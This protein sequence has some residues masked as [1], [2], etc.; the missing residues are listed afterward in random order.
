MNIE[1]DLEEFLAYLL[2]GAIVLLV[3]YPFAPMGVV[4]YLDSIKLPGP[5]LVTGGVVSLSYLGLALAAG[6]LTTVWRRFIVQPL[7]KK[8][9]GDPQYSIV[10]GKDHSFFCESAREAVSRQ[11]KMMG[12]SMDDVNNRHVIPDIIRAHVIQ[13]VPPAVVARDRWIRAR[14]L[15]GN[16]NLPLL[17]MIPLAIRFGNA[18]LALIPLAAAVL[19]AARQFTLDRR[20]SRALVIHFILISPSKLEI[21]NSVRPPR[22]L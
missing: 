14:S 13:N 18:W 16:L 1:F 12:F 15:G 17:L 3:A 21:P 6:Q 2:P 8:C 20:E 10:D 4:S 7:I 22:S 5:A 11:L 9:L 19:L